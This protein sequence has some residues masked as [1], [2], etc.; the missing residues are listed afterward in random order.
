MTGRGLPSQQCTIKALS[1]ILKPWSSHQQGEPDGDDERNPLDDA[2][3]AAQQEAT[4]SHTSKGPETKSAHVDRAPPAETDHHQGSTS[5]AAPVPLDAPATREAD[6]PYKSESFVHSVEGLIHLVSETIQQDK[7]EID[8]E[9]PR[10]DA[11]LNSH[12]DNQVQQLFKDILAVFKFDAKDLDNVIMLGDLVSNPRDP[13]L[14]MYRGATR[15]EQGKMLAYLYNKGYKIRCANCPEPTPYAAVLEGLGFD[16]NQAD[17]LAI[18][19]NQIL[20]ECCSQMS[21]DS[22]H[23]G[24]SFASSSN[25][26]FSH[27]PRSH[28]SPT[29]LTV[30]PRRSPRRR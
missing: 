28:Q 29:L 14:E 20:K 9:T 26:R 5:Q 27:C 15:D 23:Q 12:Q 11:L 4:P 17:A 19:V 10:P 22:A 25:T 8:S 13:A 16:A 1:A 2:F 24:S 30:S 21:K 7:M 3:K 6:S 18:V